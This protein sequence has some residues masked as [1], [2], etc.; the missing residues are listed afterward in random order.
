MYSGSFQYT[1]QSAALSGTW[2]FMHGARN[3][4]GWG[5]SGLCVRIS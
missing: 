4:G 1:T 2:R 5:V 3:D